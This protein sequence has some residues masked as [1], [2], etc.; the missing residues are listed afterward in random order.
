MR[1]FLF[2]VCLVVMAFAAATAQEPESAFSQ[3]YEGPHWKV[4][5]GLTLALHD[6][7]VPD[8]GA[9]RGLLRIILPLEP[10]EAGAKSLNFIAVEPCVQEGIRA[11]SEL[12]PSPSD[13]QRGVKFW[14]GDVS[15]TRTRL[16]QTIRMEKFENGAHPYLIA[17]L[18]ADKPMEVRFEVY[19][20]PDSA[21]MKACI[22]TATMGNYQRLRVLKLKDR[23]A[24]VEDL[25]PNDPG[26]HFSPH[27]VVPLSQLLR[28]KAGAV[29]YSEGNEN[30]PKVLSAQLPQRSHWRYYGPN[31]TQYWRQPE[32]VDP[33][34]RVLVNAR[35]VYWAG[36]I[37]IPGGKSFENFEMNA[38]FHPGQVFIYGVR[39]PTANP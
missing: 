21:P 16:R 15:R 12:Q 22:L 30:D 13:G 23:T 37:P 17:E 3:P 5:G 6:A 29:V 27:A 8:D 18:R 26:D 36:T 25:L 32:P 39:P 19:A 31:F 11:L 2:V 20:E 9:P 34:L 10:G 28:N 35:K 38:A 33:D 4:R 1:E 7:K 24:T 14:F